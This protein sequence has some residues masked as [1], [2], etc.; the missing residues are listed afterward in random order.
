M[1]LDFYLEAL[2]LLIAYAIVSAELAARRTRSAGLAM[3]RVAR[4]RFARW[5]GNG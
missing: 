3:V 5:V 4:E 1:T 2:S